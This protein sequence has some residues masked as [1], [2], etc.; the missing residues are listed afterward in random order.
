MSARCLMATPPTLQQSEADFIM[1]VLYMT[2]KSLEQKQ[3]WM[4][5]MPT[6]VKLVSGI[7]DT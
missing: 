1:S 7:A 5:T 2:S 6:E 4:Q 3:K